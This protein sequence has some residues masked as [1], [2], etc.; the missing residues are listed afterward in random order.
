MFKQN[1]FLEEYNSITTKARSRGLTKPF[2]ES[3]NYVYYEIHHIIPRSMGGEDNAANTVLLTA[4]EHY[5][6][7]ELLPMFTS[8]ENKAKMIYAWNMMSRIKGVKIDSNLYQRHKEMLS[9]QV[10]ARRKGS[11]SSPETVELGRQNHARYWKGKHLTDEHKAKI[12]QTRKKNKTAAG[13][14]NPMFGIGGM[15]GKSHSE[16]TKKVMSDNMKRIHA[17][18]TELICPHCNKKGGR[19]MK[20]WHFDNCKHK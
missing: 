16:H 15:L 6:C 14:N 18:E 19:I 7:H 2:K 17:S 4:Q 3:R 12:S 1:E 13:S 11:K 8:G 10:S 20:R 5:R 9:D